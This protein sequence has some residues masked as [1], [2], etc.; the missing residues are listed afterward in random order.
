MVR[1]LHFSDLHLGVGSYGRLDPNTG[2]S[3]RIGDY[4]SSLDCV[5][6][7]ALENDVH[8]VLFAGD[9]YKTCDPTPTLQ[10]EFA[11]RIGCLARAGVPTVLLPGNHDVPNARGRANSVA[12]F[13][14][15]GV[16][17]VYVPNEPATLRLETKAGPIQIVA[18]PWLGRSLL[19]SL[20]E[21]KNKSIDE[22]RETILEKAENIVMGEIETLDPAVPAIFLAHASVFGATFSSEQRTMLGQ[23]LVLPSSL[24]T[25]SAFDYVALGHVHKY[26]VLNDV[27]PVV[28]SG[29]LERIDFGEEK[30]QKGFVVAEVTRGKAEYEFV[31]TPARRFLTIRVKATGKT[32]MDGISRTVADYD[33]RD[34]VVRMI[35]QTTAESEPLIDDKAC[36]Q[37][38][39][40][41]FHVAAIVRDVERS[42]RV[43]LG[44]QTTVESLSPR[45]LLT[46]YFRYREV[47]PD[48]MSLLLEHADQLMT[49]IQ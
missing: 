24:Y 39:T 48:R 1:L 27:P 20:D 17:N 21:H 36:R 8:L 34:A 19:T 30:E 44:Q 3:S 11:I 33:V 9:A 45:E 26:Q 4:L 10:R 37:L 15:L 12:I 31:P 2:L 13:G 14:T 18:L 22:I 43:R 6:D 47:E 42:E 25:H 32:P 5:V 28:Y 41:A 7:H 46:E 49:E 29:S 16:D 40:D 23:D 38:L 35:I